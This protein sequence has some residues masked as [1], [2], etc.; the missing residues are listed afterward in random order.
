[1]ARKCLTGILKL[2]HFL[3]LEV[4]STSPA[5]LSL[6]SWYPVLILNMGEVEE[7][8]PVFRTILHSSRIGGYFLSLFFK[9]FNTVFFFFYNCPYFTFFC[10]FGDLSITTNPNVLP[11]LDCST[12]F[13][14]ADSLS[15][16]PFHSFSFSPFSSFP[17]LPPPPLFSWPPPGPPT[18]SPH[19]SPSS[20]LS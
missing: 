10:C 11:F 4:F 5:Y 12:S 6:T 2:I 20:P 18:P 14:Y 9:L 1:M 8:H 16:W 7:W 17:L 19:P 13:H 15:I 3:K